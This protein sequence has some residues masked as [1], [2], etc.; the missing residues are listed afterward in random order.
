MN[1]QYLAIVTVVVDKGGSFQQVLQLVRFDEDSVLVLYQNNL[2]QNINQ[3]QRGNDDFILEKFDK[4]KIDQV[5]SGGN[6]LK[7]R[8]A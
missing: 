7:L 4:H 1:N 3:I 2:P 5:I 6:L 8:V